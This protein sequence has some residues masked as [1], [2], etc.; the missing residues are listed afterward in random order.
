MIRG[1][2]FH[3]TKVG[4]GPAMR[5]LSL[6]R[7]SGRESDS[8]FLELELERNAYAPGTARAAVSERLE[9]H[10][11]DAALEQTVVLLVSEVVSNAVRHSMASTERPIELAATVTRDWVRVAVS[12]G[13]RGF[14][15]RQRDP[16]RLSDGYGLFLLEKTA[17]SWGVEDAGGTTVWF[18]LPR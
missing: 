3:D 9:E 12:D 18:E 2:D 7:D 15:P 17:S 4:E 14:V 10:G 13:G 11:I 16:T 1:Q 5:A 8:S 6:N